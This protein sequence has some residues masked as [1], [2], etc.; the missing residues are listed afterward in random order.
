MVRAKL[1][2]RTSATHRRRTSGPWHSRRRRSLLKQREEQYYCCSLIYKVPIFGMVGASARYSG[3][4]IPV[5]T[6]TAPSSICPCRFPSSPSVGSEDVH[7]WGNL[8]SKPKLASVL[9]GEG[10]LFLSKPKLASVLFGEGLLLLSKPKLASVLFGEVW[11]EYT[12][13]LSISSGGG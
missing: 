13:A 5:E 10:L 8:L 12:A 2:A 9:F 11:R 4:R 1:C 6:V 7:L 3:F